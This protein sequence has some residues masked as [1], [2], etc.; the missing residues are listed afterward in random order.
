VKVKNVSNLAELT[1]IDAAL[2][3]LDEARRPANPQLSM[4][5]PIGPITAVATQRH[6]LVGIGGSVGARPRRRSP[7]RLDLRI[8]VA[9]VADD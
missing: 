9:T 1:R 3:T 4:M 8:E 6:P 7:L 5:G 2:A